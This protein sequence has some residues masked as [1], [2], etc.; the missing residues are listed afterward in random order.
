MY[1]PISIHFLYGFISIKNGN[2][3]KYVFYISAKY[4]S[5]FGFMFDVRV[6]C[7]H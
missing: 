5:P 2:S 3:H 7:K 4:K 6:L 1:L